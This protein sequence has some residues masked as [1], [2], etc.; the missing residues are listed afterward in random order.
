VSLQVTATTASGRRPAP[1][2]L[3]R[4]NRFATRESPNSTSPIEKTEEVDVEGKAGITGP[5]PNDVTSRDYAT[6]SP[7]SPSPNS[8]ATPDN[9]SIV[10]SELFHRG[11]ASAVRVAAS[12]AASTATVSATGGGAVVDVQQDEAREHDLSVDSPIAPQKSVRFP[13]ARE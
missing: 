1:E 3:L 8:Y 4:V 5:N 7:T 6:M 9:R 12:G 11:S 13:E 2:W 10:D